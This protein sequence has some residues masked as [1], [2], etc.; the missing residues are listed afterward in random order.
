MMHS[1]TT[2]I[3]PELGRGSPLP[4][5]SSKVLDI[6]SELNDD[7]KPTLG[8]CCLYLRSSPNFSKLFTSYGAESRHEKSFRT[9]FTLLHS[10]F[11]KQSVQS[12][13][14]RK[15]TTGNTKESASD[16]TTAASK[17]FQLLKERIALVQIF[18][19]QSGSLL[20][21]TLTRFCRSSHHLL[22]M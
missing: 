22:I 19:C 4:E 13:R 18:V 6:M 20:V 16:M 11:T 10:M 1:C 2:P 9:R 7:F 5:P 12:S 17:H 14:H 21:V 8:I 15:A 3:Q